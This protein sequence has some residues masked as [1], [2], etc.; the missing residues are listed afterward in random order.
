MCIHDVYRC[1]IQIIKKK[2]IVTYKFHRQNWTKK[3]N[4][5]CFSFQG[6]WTKTERY[7][8]VFLFYAKLTQ[9]CFYKSTFDVSV[10]LFEDTDAFRSWLLCLSLT[11]NIARKEVRP[12]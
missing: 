6:V 1:V 3:L 7:A 11:F 8:Q 2:H 12:T 10:F 5:G 4:L 9:E